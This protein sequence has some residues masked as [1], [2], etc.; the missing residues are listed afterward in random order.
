MRERDTSKQG[1]TIQPS[2][3]RAEDTYYCLLYVF[4]LLLLQTVDYEAPANTARHC[5][6]DPASK[7]DT[8]QLFTNRMTFQFLVYILCKER[9][10]PPGFSCVIL[11]RLKQYTLQSTA[12]CGS[13]IR[14]VTPQ[15]YYTTCCRPCT[16]ARS[17]E[18]LPSLVAQSN[19]T[20][21]INSQAVGYVSSKFQCYRTTWKL[22]LKH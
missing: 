12:D 3:D 17:I 16:S 15:L 1:F 14:C 21:L 11:G 13:D 22:T 9:K 20:T 7:S 19:V 2:I 8:Y 6:D 10:P 18:T 5:F 4:R